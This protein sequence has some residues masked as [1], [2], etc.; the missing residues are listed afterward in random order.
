[1]MIKKGKKQLEIDR[2]GN[3]N[4]WIKQWISAKEVD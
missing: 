4:C 2:I 3:K 1:M